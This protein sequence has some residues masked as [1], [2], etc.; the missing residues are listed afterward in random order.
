MRCGSTRLD[1]CSQPPT[2]GPALDGLGDAAAAGVHARL[3]AL[4]RAL[5]APAPAHA[6]AEGGAGAERGPAAAHAAH[7]HARTCRALGELFLEVGERVILPERIRRV[8][9]GMS[10]TP[11]CQI[12]YMDHTGWAVIN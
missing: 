9:F 4:H 11:G 7:A 6:E 2:V 8:G 1:L 12:D 10:L 3:G 5:G